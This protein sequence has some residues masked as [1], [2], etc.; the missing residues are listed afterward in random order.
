MNLLLRI[1]ANLLAM[2]Q[3]SLEG[4]EAFCIGVF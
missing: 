2:K 3:K 4:L 1:K